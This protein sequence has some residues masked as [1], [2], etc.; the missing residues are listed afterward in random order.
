MLLLSCL[1]VILMLQSIDGQ[2]CAAATPRRTVLLQYGANL[3]G[4]GDEMAGEFRFPTEKGM[5]VS[6]PV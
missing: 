6:L 1:S 4:V 2:P 3:V 5:H